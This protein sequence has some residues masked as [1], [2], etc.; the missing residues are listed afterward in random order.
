MENYKTI[1]ICNYNTTKLTNN[2]IKSIIDN[3]KSF[4]YKI[5][6]FDN[7]D[8]EKFILENQQFNEKIIYIDNTKQQIL[9]FDDLLKKYLKLDHKHSNNGSMKH[10]Y[11]LQHII[12]TCKTD[13]L[14]IID[15]DAVLLKDIDF[16]NNNYITVA[17]IQLHDK[18]IG[19]NNPKPYWSYSR[20]IPFIQYLNVK[21]IKDN[22]I[23]FFD[24]YRIQGG[25]VYEANRYDTG[26]SFYED[27]I[28]KNLK[29]KQIIFTD[30]IYHI[31]G[32]SWHVFDK[33]FSNRLNT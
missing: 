24:P 32:S 1:A 15:S 28:S 10:C 26:A 25:L 13:D 6:L 12:S 8:K 11:T 31:G 22:N 7:S 5:L 14:I 9:N 29:Y 23:N 30:Y 21:Q 18:P 17:D 33:R 16:I 20:F 19:D 2:C 27:V 4:N 3:I